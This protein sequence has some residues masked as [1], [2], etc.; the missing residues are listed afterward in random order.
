MKEYRCDILVIGAGP[1][2]ASAARSALFSGLSI[3]LIDGKH[4]IGKPVRCAEYIPKQL[5]GELDLKKDFIVQQISKMKTFLADQK[6]IETTSPGYIIDRE[7]FDH[8]LLL[9]A[10]DAGVDVWPGCRAL[11]REGGC[12]TVR[13]DGKYIKIKPEIIIGADGP[14]SKAAKW[15]G[16]ENR[17]L[18]PAVQ[19]SITLAAPLDDT[20]IYFHEDFF[21]G[22]G[23]LFPRK[24]KGNLG[25]GMKPGPGYPAIKESL[26]RLIKILRDTGKVKG[27]PESFTAGWIP[28]ERPRKITAGNIILTGDAAGQAHPITGAGIAQ[29]VICGKMA[30]KWAAR[31]VSEND[32]GLV[33][34]YEKEWYDLYGESQERAFRKRELL[35]KNWDDLDNVIKKCW[36]AFREYYRDN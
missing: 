12:V 28:A 6:L 8:A 3:L 1:A 34:E 17:N 10:K 35:E 30:G 13:K 27:E 9:K 25:L 32:I 2:G 23:W 31:A 20:E 11:F 24:D 5:T 29:A 26:N 22:Y 18:I 36:V 7:R 21:G 33:S 15:I 19:S 14:R 4:T 16:S